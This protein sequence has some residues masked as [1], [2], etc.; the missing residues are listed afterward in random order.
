[1]RLEMLLNWITEGMPINPFVG[2]CY[3]NPM[4]SRYKG[5]A[6]YE[7]ISDKLLNSALSFSRSYFNNKE[8]A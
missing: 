4:L 5:P 1:M 3:N 6:K 2:T 8:K 7:S